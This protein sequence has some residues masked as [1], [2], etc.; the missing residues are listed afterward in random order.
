MASPACVVAGMTRLSSHFR[1]QRTEAE[2]AI[3][4][5]DWREALARFPDHL[6]SRAVDNWIISYDRFPTLSQFIEATLVEARLI[7]REQYEARRE[8]RPDIPTEL[9]PN[10][11]VA[12]R[13]IH[14]ARVMKML[15]AQSWEEM[16]QRAAMD[17]SLFEEPK[18]LLPSV[19]RG[20]IDPRGHDHSKGR[21]N[22]RVCGPHD[23]SSPNWREDCPECGSPLP[24]LYVWS[25]CAGCDGSGYV[26]QGVG[27][28]G[29]VIPCFR[30]NEET[31]SLWEGGHFALNHRCEVCTR[32][33]PRRSV[34][35]ARA[36][37]GTSGSD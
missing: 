23:H 35:S 10:P 1:V 31:Y 8:G 27:G 6:V 9:I 12:L 3:I 13:A 21:E 26:P 24:V 22:C 33:T 7:R 30:C 14:V 11:K 5:A 36:E 34:G 15:P 37:R 28:Y 19:E 4:A 32:S 25:V 17:V 29:P 20:G 18:S 2:A 16:E